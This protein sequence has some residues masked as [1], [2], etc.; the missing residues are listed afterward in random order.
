MTKLKIA[1]IG[2]G[3]IARA[4]LTAIRNNADHAEL[5][6]VV[7]LP[8]D[9]ERIASLAAEFHAKFTSQDLEAI[10]A[11]P[12]IDAV[13]LTLPNHLHR[14]VAEKALT[15]GK[16]VLVEKPLCNTLEEA[17]AMTAAAETADRVLM[18]AQCRRFFPAPDVA[19]ERLP[20]PGPPLDIVQIL[21]VHVAE[22]QAPWWKSAAATGGLALGLNGPHA[23]DT[24]ILLMG[25]MPESVFARTSRLKVD[26]WEGE[27]QATVVMSFADGSTATAHLS[28]NMQPGA[29]ERW[30]VGPKAM[31]HLQ[32]DRTL[33]L[34]DEVL[35]EDDFK[36]YIDG[37][38]SFDRQFREFCD[39]ISEGRQPR[40]SGQDGRNVVAVLNAALRSAKTGLPEKP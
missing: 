21:G 16:H 34:G 13:V 31:M 11:D 30:I 37:D 10:L 33:K 39:A 1:V 26:N 8:E 4:H 2:P 29:N 40:S 9:A 28:F 5:A 38:I 22:A 3:R 23:I 20:E 18:V 19:I 24:I 32:N 7:G 14:Q 15:A 17:D 36:P 6:A 12:E 27:D 25:E 35:I